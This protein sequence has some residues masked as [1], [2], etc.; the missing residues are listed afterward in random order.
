MYGPLTGGGNDLIIADDIIDQS[1][2]IT[3]LQVEKA[4]TWFHKVLLTTL[5][6][7]GA[8]LVIGTRWSYNDLYS[9][10][11]E[12]WNHEIL[13]AI[14][15]PTEYAEGKPAKVLWHDYWP[16]ERLE[17]KRKEIGTIFFN[18]QYQNDPTGM[19]G[20]LL[21][22]EWLHPWLAPPPT[23]I[24]KF[25]GVD[26][27]LGEGDLS[28][29][30]T[31]SYDHTNRQGYLVD[32]WAERVPFPTFLQT[33]RQ[34]H[35]LHQYAKIYIE[36]NAFQKI[37]TFLPELKGLPMVPTITHHD[38][39]SRFIAMSSHF[40]SKRILVNPLLL[41][42]SEF[43][44]EWAQFPRGQ[45]DDALDSVE[46]ASRNVIPSGGAVDAWKFG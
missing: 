1:N 11:L 37:L 38:K 10:L 24:P 28:S 18:C 44:N 35:V 19:E 31:E 8:V 43:W 25:A 22:S 2:I 32:V 34:Q 13:K 27:A 12:K 30:A 7:W 14:L 36:S 23:N 29:I 5:F 45:Y 41:R 21:K 17:D 4:S 20:E 39:E 3:R 42:R 26:P 6:P 40:E 15:N 46:I 33:L 9:E 16:I